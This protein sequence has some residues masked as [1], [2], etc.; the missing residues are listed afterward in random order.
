MIVHRMFRRVLFG[1]SLLLALATASA[2]A[3]EP[4][5]GEAPVVG[6][7]VSG[8][9]ERA[10]AD[11]FRKAV[12]TVFDEARSGIAGA[13]AAVASLRDVMGQRARRYIRSFRLVE[14]A[15][16][17]GYIRVKLT[18]DVDRVAITRELESVAGTSAQTSVPGVLVAGGDPA[19]NIF[20]KALQLR[21]VRARQGSGAPAEGQLLVQIFGSDKA[22]LPVRGTRTLA[23]ACELKVKI[24]RTGSGTDTTV[25][26]WGVRRRR[27]GG[28]G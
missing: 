27:S 13:Q 18:A 14:Q 17:G 24:V 1:F 4:I 15:E 20:T 10:L 6:G 21:G 9:R 25:T 12:E 23:A 19:A 11:A 2:A 26:G 28:A 8:A 22:I 7:N 3:Q 5:L 16:E